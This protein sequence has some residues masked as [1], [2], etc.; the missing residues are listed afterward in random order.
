[1][2][3]FT[4]NVLVIKEATA[5]IYRIPLAY[6]SVMAAMVNSPANLL[7]AATIHEG[8]FAHEGY[9]KVWKVGR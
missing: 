3:S 5:N 1:M 8:R 6:I 4:K 7:I 2:M 9:W